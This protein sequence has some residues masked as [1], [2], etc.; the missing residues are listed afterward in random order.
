MNNEQILADFDCQALVSLQ[1]KGGL[2][3]EFSLFCSSSTGTMKDIGGTASLYDF[4]STIQ[5]IL[6]SC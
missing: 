6:S 5:K 4:S 2:V 3:G 1:I